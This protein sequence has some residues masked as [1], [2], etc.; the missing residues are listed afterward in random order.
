M[1]AEKEKPQ[2]QNKEKKEEVK[3]EKPSFFL[4]LIYS[5]GSF[6]KNALAS[7]VSSIQTLFGIKRDVYVDE[8]KMKGME[9]DMHNVGH[10]QEM[11]VH[12]D[13]VQKAK[14]EFEAIHPKEKQEQQT[15]QVYQSEVN[16]DD[17]VQTTKD[18][19]RIS[20]VED[21][22]QQ[23]LAETKVHTGN[24]MIFDPKDVPPLSSE[25]MEDYIEMPEQP[26]S[27][28]ENSEI[29]E[30]PMPAGEKEVITEYS[31]FDNFDDLKKHINEINKNV[32]IFIKDGKLMISSLSFDGD[33]TYP[34]NA[35]ET[36]AEFF[37]EQSLL[38]ADDAHSIICLLNANKD[39][40]QKTINKEKENEKMIME[41]AKSIEFKSM[42]DVITHGM[43]LFKGS[44]PNDFKV[45]EYNGATNLVIRQH[46][47]GDGKT[48]IDSIQINLDN[49]NVSKE[50]LSFARGGM[51]SE[52]LTM[53]KSEFSP[54]LRIFVDA[55]KGNKEFFEKN[56][57]I[58]H[59]NNKHTIADTVLEYED[60]GRF[61][62]SEKR[63]AK[64]EAMAEKEQRE[65]KAYNQTGLEGTTKR[66]SRQGGSHRNNRDRFDDDDLDK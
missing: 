3:K 11:Y 51:Q 37:A 24:N 27:I 25:F 66:H 19:D 31:V 53:D 41:T 7:I 33:I 54:E 5:I 58:S 64:E 18:E 20:D 17:V 29:A 42:D 50:M 34:E 40:I 12:G 45:E 39:I 52:T 36:F 16:S 8:L 59:G 35:D 22:S 26:S 57:H 23:T 30:L 56:F 60:E 21:V 63:K 10:K 38:N 6:F 32:D 44:N 14:E 65:E 61:D 15:E 4:S 48:F 2:V 47:S 62:L 43:E 46:D 55:V 9:S 13:E 1:V 28:N 49:F